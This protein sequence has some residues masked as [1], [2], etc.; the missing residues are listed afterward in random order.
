[1][2]SCGRTYRLGELRVV[3]S[4]VDVWE[5]TVGIVSDENRGDHTGECLR[6]AESA[7]AMLG[8]AEL[9]AWFYCGEG[10]SQK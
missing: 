7:D 8:T 5:N 6:D 10:R 2:R 9:W 1:M 3:G 4:V